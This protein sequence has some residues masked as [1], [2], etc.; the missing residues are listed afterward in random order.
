MIKIL[1]ADDQQLVRE[2]LGALL[3]LQP[4]LELVGTC[5]RGDEVF[6][7]VEQSSPDVVLLD[8]EMPAMNG[9]EVAAQLKERKVACRSL[10]VTTFGR[11]GYLSRALEAGACGFV[12]KDTPAAQLAETIR[13]V[14][15]GLRVVD[16]ALAAES[17]SVG[18]SPLTDREHQVLV[19][20]QSGAS[21]SAIA[22]NLHLSQ[23]TVRN[24][25]SSA[26]TKL[27]ASNRFDAARLARERGWL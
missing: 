2:A 18:S 23:G 16:P 26:I 11:P 27:E 3:S 17:F 7:L 13:K 1:I 12:V 24:H 9:I 21:V 8:I 25:L 4:D 15:A 5:G 22:Q 19:G 6:P 10:I 20:A 14:H